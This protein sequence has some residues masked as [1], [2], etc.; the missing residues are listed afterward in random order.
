MRNVAID[1]AV[2]GSCTNGRL[3]DLEIAAGIL[4]GKK[5]ARGVR[6]II[7][8]ATPEIYHAAL[9][10]GYFDIY[11]DAGCISRPHVRSLPWGPY[12]RA[13]PG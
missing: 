4:K 10:K 9:N 1:Q 12:G 11:L 2:I 8:P 3:E 13:C 7:I 6:C 5:V